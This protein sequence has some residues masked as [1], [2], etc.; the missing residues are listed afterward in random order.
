MLIILFG[1]LMTA[2]CLVLQTA[3]AMMA[4]RFVARAN[5]REGGAARGHGEGFARIIVT[6]TLLMLGILVQMAAWAFLYRAIGL[7]SD[8]EE[9][10]YFSGTAFTSLGFGDVLIVTNARILAPIQ[11][12]NGLMMFAIVTAILIGVIQREAR[13]P[14]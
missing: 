14:N 9:A 10:L 12:A 6:L 5:A 1:L 11:A 3:A 13:R 7:F 4:Q 8:F 2:F